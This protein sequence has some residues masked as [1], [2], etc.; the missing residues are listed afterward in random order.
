[1]NQTAKL[2]QELEYL[3]KTHSILNEEVDKLNKAG[4][5]QERVNALKLKKVDLKN[6]IENIKSKLDT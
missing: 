4:V 5:S 3:K 6:Q 1:M 2:E